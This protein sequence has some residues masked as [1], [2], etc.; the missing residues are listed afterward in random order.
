[1]T[2]DVLQATLDILSSNWNSSNTDGHTPL[3][4]KITEFKR[5]DFNQNKDIVLAQRAISEFQPAGVGDVDKHEFENFN[6]DIRV[7]GSNE[8]TH[9]LNVIKEVKRI[10]KANKVNPD[11]TNFPENHVLEWDGTAQDLSDKTHHLWRKLL[12]AQFKRFKVIRS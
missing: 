10:F 12:P 7:L 5:Y 11:L 8:E 4:K 1:M 2:A 3:F 6:M 9:W